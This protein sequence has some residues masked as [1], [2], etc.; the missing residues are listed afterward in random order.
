MA[1]IGRRSQSVSCQASQ[2]DAALIHPV[3]ML[4][5]LCRR[6][7]RAHVPPLRGTSQ[8]SSPKSL[9]EMKT[10]MALSV[11]KFRRAQIQCDVAGTLVSSEAMTIRKVKNV[12]QMSTLVSTSHCA[13][14]RKP[15]EDVVR[16]KNDGGAEEIATVGR[17][18]CHFRQKD[19]A[20]WA[21]MKVF[22]ACH[23]L[24][25]PSL[26]LSLSCRLVD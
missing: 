3:P 16:K 14:M 22:A 9:D 2:D 21:S 12:E 1:K 4:L 17:L 7:P 11:R 24:H 8:Q 13:D 18:S 23:S 19:V 6:N 20:H 10:H 15:F 25:L 26:V 5:V